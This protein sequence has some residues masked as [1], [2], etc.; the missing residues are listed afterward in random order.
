MY[1]HALSTILGYH[2]NWR[3]VQRAA[4]EAAALPHCFAAGLS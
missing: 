1:M 3:R 2:P 4:M